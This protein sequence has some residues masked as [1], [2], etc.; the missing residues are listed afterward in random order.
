MRSDVL[1]VDLDA[2]YA[3]VE[4][5]RRP[6]L[7]GR[8]LV[9][10]GRGPRGVVLSCS[11]EARASGVRNGMPSM[12][13]RRLCPDTVFVAPDFG[14]YREA[15]TAFR[16]IL[17]GFTPTIEPL[18]LDEVFCDVTGAHRMYGDSLEIAQRIRER[19]SSELALPCSVGGGPSKLIAKLASRAAKP[20]GALVVDD[21]IGFLH[22]LPV[23][24]LWGVGETT[25]ASL[26]GLGIRTV[27]D[28]AATPRWILKRT[29]GDAA[30]AELHELAHGIDARPVTPR[31]EPKSVGAE[32]TFDDDLA[33]EDRIVGELLRLADRVASR[34]D[35]QSLAGRT[36][37][38]K[39]RLGD[40]TTRT[41]ARTLSVPASDVWTVHRAAREA[42]EGS[43]RGRDRV[44]LL[45][46]SVSGLTAGSVPEQLSFDPTPPYTQAGKAL[47]EV[48]R[49]FGEEAVGFARFLGDPADRNG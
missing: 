15:S 9:V 45:G 39:V 6:E 18:S 49:R 5:R 48:R 19:V 38:V 47:S 30:G 20:D 34:L 16:Q 11:Y 23:S 40:F 43:T 31:P 29:L 26:R 41:R 22:P 33:S 13:A 37:T 35:A 25:A 17:D 12:R 44:R 10:G 21:P 28:L 46:I 14:A 4:R 32:K 42:Y 8:P 7:A 2:F 36:V 3:S 24:E 27:E 1:H